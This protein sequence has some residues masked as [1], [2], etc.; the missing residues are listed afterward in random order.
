MEGRHGT[1]FRPGKGCLT[2][3]H[4]NSILLAAIRGPDLLMRPATAR[5]RGRKQ[6]DPALGGFG[7]E[8]SPGLAHT[9][10][11]RS[12]MDRYPACCRSCEL[13]G[14]AAILSIKLR[15]AVKRV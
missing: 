9:D 8:S 11:I 14:L 7:L 2:L 10:W 15:L 4:R 12:G 3:A 13:T 6:L 1:D 5:E